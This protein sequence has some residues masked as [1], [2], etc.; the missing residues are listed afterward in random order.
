MNTVKIKPNDYFLKFSEWL[1]LT[2]VW[3]SVYFLRF[4]IF[5]GQSGL[6]LNFAWAYLLLSLSSFYF[7]SRFELYDHNQV[8]SFLE[9]TFSVFK[10]NL[11][12]QVFFVVMLYFSSENRLSRSVLLLNFIFSTIFLILNRL[13][14]K[15]KYKK[16]SGETPTR[17]LLY[18]ESDS[19]LNYLD[20]VA[21]SDSFSTEIVGWVQ[22][23]KHAEEKYSHDI[24]T[25][26]VSE[27]REKLQPDLI[28]M[29]AKSEDFSRIEKIISENY[30]QVIP[31]TVLP[32]LPYAYA[33]YHL[34]ELAGIP[35][36][37][38]NQPHF[39]SVDLMMKRAFDIFSSGLGLVLISPL[40]FVL[41]VLVK[42]TSP[43]PIFFG[44]E[45]IGLDGQ[46]FKMWKFRSMKVSAEAVS[47]WTV[48]DDPR[49]TRFGTFI[50]RTSLDELPQLWNVFVGDMSLVGPRPEQPQYV[51]KFTHEITA[52][53]LRHKM[54]AGITGW[55]QV[56]GWRGDTSLEK[57]IECDLY[58]IR[59]WT[60]WFDIKIL[61]LTFWK[62]FINR[63]AY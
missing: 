56:N 57:R 11:Y 39:R 36:L 63:N 49:R 1:I 54:K 23:G 38:I 28:L 37:K 19:L 46:K 4:Q 61:F 43:G 41:S 14:L 59:N 24:K 17:L 52:Y 9:E 21:R 42:M 16:L 48:K 5:E 40:L 2:I 62:G 30:N 18:G 15:E 25:M 33:G 27:A 35:L 31:I 26:T 20:L 47:T 8:Q 22:P 32:D 55:A 12:A 10:A 34:T 3:W 50:R 7:F 45:R 44:Q 6:F 60:F 58:Y 51:A 29:G 13:T 53:M